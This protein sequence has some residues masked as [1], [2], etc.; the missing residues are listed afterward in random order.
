MK[1]SALRT[2]MTRSGLLLRVLFLV[3]FTTVLAA[4]SN[5]SSDFSDGVDLP[6]DD[7]PGTSTTDPDDGSGEDDDDA[8]LQVFNETGAAGM[9]VTYSPA[10]L[11]AFTDVDELEAIYADVMA[12]VGVTTSLYPAM[13]LTDDP[14]VKVL[15]EDGVEYEGYY[16]ESQD[17][18]V[19]YSEDIDPSLGNQFYWTRTG[20]IDYIMVMTGVT[21]TSSRYTPFSGCRYNN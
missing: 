7:D 18:I 9:S 13:L 8:Q 14:T 15:R 6:L 1:T 19:V 11:T 3:L 10:L 16:D 21:D 2:P 5:S 4:C 20:M 12:C 17:R